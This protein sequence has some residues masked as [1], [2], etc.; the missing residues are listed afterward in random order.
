M[1]DAENSCPAQLLGD[2]LDLPCRYALHVHLGQSSDQ[3]LLTSLIPLEDL[4]PEPSLSILRHPQ[5]QLPHPCDQC[6]PVIPGTVSLP[7]RC[8]LAFVGSQHLL[9]LGFHHLL[10]HLSDQRSK[11]IR[12]IANHLFPLQSVRAMLLSGHLLSFLSP[13]NGPVQGLSCPLPLLQ[14]SQSITR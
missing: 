11:E 14:N 6:A 12:L 2:G 4:G 1:V 8:A 5:F 9:H 10:Q 13:V 7:I 3:R